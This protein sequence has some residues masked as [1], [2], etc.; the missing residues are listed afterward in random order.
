[1][2]RLDTPQPALRAG[3]PSTS[4]ERAHTN[5]VPQTA[6]GP[7]AQG[8]LEAPPLRRPSSWGSRLLAS[9]ATGG[10][11]SQATC[12]CA[13]DPPALCKRSGHGIHRV[14]FISQQKRCLFGNH[15]VTVLQPRADLPPGKEKFPLLSSLWLSDA[16][17]ESTEHSF[18]S[19]Q[20]GFHLRAPADPHP[21]PRA[22]L[23]AF[24]TATPPACPAVP[25]QLL[26]WR[27]LCPSQKS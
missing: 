22:P 27:S 8:L 20:A 1:M 16:S 14:V 23:P 19:V 7:G 26:L 4:G 5:P 17:S 11:Q 6:P 10:A 2:C 12:Q 9:G 3:P 21:L 13:C 25:P 18:S 24:L 15:L